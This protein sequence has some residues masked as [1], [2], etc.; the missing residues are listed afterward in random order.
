MRFGELHLLKYGNFEGCDLTFPKQPIDF[1]VIF[2]PN[3]AGKSTT[4]SAVGDLL[5]GFP[6]RISQAY[7]FDAS[8][9]RVG[10]ILEQGSQQTQ[11]RRKRG[12]GSLMDGRDNSVDETV[13]AGMLHG[14][15][16]HF[17]MVVDDDDFVSRRIAGFVREHADADGWTLRKGYLWTE[18]GAHL[19]EHDDFSG[20]CCS[21]SRCLCIFTRGRGVR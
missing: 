6:S 5:F 2:G 19:Y 21:A 4:L 15:R 11:I 10:G 18:G 13:L 3:E 12:R 9:L 1:H 20:I 17:F 16:P 7:R 14:T 8:L